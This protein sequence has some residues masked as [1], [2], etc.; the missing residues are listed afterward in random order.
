MGIVTSI[1]VEKGYA[2]LEKDEHK[3]Y[4]YPKLQAA[5]TTPKVVVKTVKGKPLEINMKQLAVAMLIWADERNHDYLWY[6]KAEVTFNVPKSGTPVPVLTNSSKEKNR[7]HSHNP[8]G[9]V[10]AGAQRRRPDIIV[11]KDK[12]IRWPGLAATYP[13]GEKYGDNLSRV[14]EVK[15]DN[16][17]LDKQQGKDYEKIAGGSRERFTVLKVSSK[18]TGGKTAADML[19][20]YAPKPEPEGYFWEEW[21][22]GARQSADSL[23]ISLE[24]QYQ[25]YKR[26]ITAYSQEAANY[27]RQQAP[28]VFEGGRFVQDKA[29]AV[30]KWVDETGKTVKTWTQQQLDAAMKQIQAATDWTI[31]EFKKIDWFQVIAVG[32]VIVLAIAIGAA[33][34]FFSAGTATAPYVAAVQAFLVTLGIGGTMAAA[35]R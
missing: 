20:I 1:E 3:S 10:I 5:N 4:L 15:F 34:T 26:T 6:Y 9:Q 8:F 31:A 23:L 27:L 12:N 18:D 32:G 14:V 33:V 11:V 2:Q 30:W 16:D 19:P 24:N 13:T 17:R 21:V 35:T 29:K 22:K 28:W 25:G 7:R